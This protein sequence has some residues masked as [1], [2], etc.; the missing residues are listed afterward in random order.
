[1]GAAQ[2]S[3]KVHHNNKSQDMHKEITTCFAKTLHDERK[4]HLEKLKKMDGSALE[5]HLKKIL[6]ERCVLKFGEGAVENKWVKA[7]SNANACAFAKAIKD[8]CYTSTNPKSCEKDAAM[9]CLLRKSTP[10]VTPKRRALK[11]PKSLDS[12]VSKISKSKSKK[13]RKSLNSSKS[14]K[15][16]KSLKSQKS[17]KS[18]NSR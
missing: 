16:R 5:S 12:K 11:S 15:S 18:R 2:S 9:L 3:E 6:H 10:K 4:D 14:S 13:S 17:R 1:M 7:L 8:G